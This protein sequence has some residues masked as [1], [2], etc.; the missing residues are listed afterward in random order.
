M[1]FRFSRDKR[2]LSRVTFAEFMS[3]AGALAALIRAKRPSATIEVLTFES[4]G[5]SWK[6]P[7][8]EFYGDSVMETDEYLAYSLE[9]FSENVWSRAYDVQLTVKDPSDE[10]PFMVCMSC[11]RRP[12]MKSLFFYGQCVDEPLFAQIYSQFGQPDRATSIGAKKND[13]SVI[14]IIEHKRVA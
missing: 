4:T 12:V 5:K 1:S 7:G 9:Q 3:T 6:Y 13:N 11:S 2:F 14:G 8:V 10:Q